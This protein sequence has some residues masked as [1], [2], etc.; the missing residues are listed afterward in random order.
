MTRAA[1]PSADRLLGFLDGVKVSLEGSGLFEDV[2]LS[3]DPYAVED[4][5]K[6]NTRMPAARIFVLRMASE[7]QGRSSRDLTVTLG[8]AVLARREGRPDLSVASADIMALGLTLDVASLI[9]HDPYFGMTQITAAKDEGYRVVTSEK[10]N[11]KALAI[12]LL[13]VSTT[14]LE[15]IPVWPGAAD[16]FDATRH[17]GTGL[18]I[19]SDIMELNP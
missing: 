9:Q 5:T 10:S 11:D 2:R 19:N 7:Q 14:L 6:E 15:L 3:L 17:A 13:Q 16:I 12:T 8:I 1:S 18:T 4:I